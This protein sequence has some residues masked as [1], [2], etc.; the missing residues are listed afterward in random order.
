MKTAVIIILIVLAVILAA[1]I[2]LMIY[3]RKL[4]KKSEESQAQMKAGAQTV[5]ILVIDKKR[6]KL[7]EA[8]LPKIVVDQTPKYLRG[9]KVPIVKAKIGPKIMTLMCDDKVF[10]L[11]PIKKEVK[12]VMNGIYIMDVKGLRSNLDVKPE[13]QKFFQKIKNKLSNKEKA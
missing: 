6:M 2:G 9:S 12:A 5:S 13:K 4:Q 1:F 10:D 11:I 8:N 7:K 3:G